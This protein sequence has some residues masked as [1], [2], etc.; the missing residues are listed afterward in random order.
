MDDDMSKGFLRRA[1]QEIFSNPGQSAQEI[2][3]KLLDSGEA[4]SRA[5]NPELSLVATLS[6]HY[7]DIEVV[8]RKIDGLY[9]YF[10]A[11]DYFPSAD[12]N[13]FEP[14]PP[15]GVPDI[16]DT[17]LLVE[18]EDTEFA[19]ALVITGRCKTREDALRLMLSKGREAI[20][21]NIGRV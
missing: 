6:K 3:R 8:R 16:T 21:E 4:E 18:T 12:S 15:K 11:H 20:R 10:P 2:A 14:L 5:Q 19:D 13:S 17:S 7:M 1:K 9:R